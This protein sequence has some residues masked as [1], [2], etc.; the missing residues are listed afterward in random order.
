MTDCLLED[1]HLKTYPLYFY[2]QL[3]E[4]IDR[5]PYAI[6]K[7]TVPLFTYTGISTLKVYK[8][9]PYANYII[10]KETIPFERMQVAISRP[11]NL[12]DILT[13]AAITLPHGYD[14]NKV[15]QE[16]ATKTTDP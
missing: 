6:R 16:C 1:T 10:L 13:K 9:K 11:R 2:K 3:Q 12:R 8:G 15:I 7:K 14:I 5:L 4:L